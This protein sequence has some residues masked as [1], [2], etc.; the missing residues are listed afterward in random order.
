MFADPRRGVKPL[1][2]WQ[3]P[4]VHTEVNVAEPALKG[5]RALVTGAN[6]GI[7]AE[8]ARALAR[9]GAQ[10][11][12]NY[13]SRPDDA[14]AVV[15][16]IEQEG[17][18]ALALQADV[19]APGQVAAMFEFMDRQLHGID[20]LV[21]NAGVQNPA[22]VLDLELG[23]FERVL[24]VNLRGPFLCAQEAARR[25]VPQGAGVILNISSV[26]EHIPHARYAHY[27]ASKG[28]L[29]MLMKTFALELA[30]RGVRVNNIAPGAIATRMNRDW[31][32][33]PERQQQ[34]AAKIPAGRVGEPE[35]IADAAVFLASD[36]AR[37][38]TGTTLFVDGGMTLYQNF[39]AD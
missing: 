26:H 32:H 31:L 1:S 9:A 28:G 3:R 6:S 2:L 10:V 39:A 7:G 34:V 12:V 24:D 33:T 14:A 27:C 23:D 18:R 13:R 17:G 25:M 4:N 36:A 22:S 35:E 37:Y 21:N 38:I 8:V 11:V 5:R 29:K 20:I 15:A 30:S 16:D 19:S